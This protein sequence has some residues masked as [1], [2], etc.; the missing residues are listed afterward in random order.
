MKAPE[1]YIHIGTHKT[2]STAIRQALIQCREA[3][4]GQG[5]LYLPWDVRTFPR[6]SLSFMTMR[7][8]DQ[9]AVHHLR[10]M[11]RQARGDQRRGD[12]EG[13]RLL[14]SFEGFSGDPS[15]GYRNASV[16]AEHLRRATEGFK[17]HIIVYLR[18]QDEFIE[19]LYTQQIHEG[20]WCSFPDFV[21]RHD[22]SS[23][24]NWH[25]LLR[26]YSNCFGKDRMIVRRYHKQFF[27]CNESLL[28]DFFRILG[29]D[30][31]VLDL[32]PDFA[33]NRGYSR[34]ALEIAR[35]ANPHLTDAER[36][37][38]RQLLQ[39]TNAKQPFEAYAFWS[40]REREALASRYRESNA[41]VAQEYFGE[42]SG[43]LFPS[44]GSRHEEVKYAGLSL[45][46]VTLAFA[47]IIL[48]E[49]DRPVV[50]E[51]ASNNESVLLKALVRVEKRASALLKKGS[52][53]VSRLRSLI[54][55]S[56]PLEAGA[57]VRGALGSE[58]VCAMGSDHPMS[59]IPVRHLW[60]SR[61]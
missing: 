42:S 18:P 37:R 29:V 50:I 32:P 40:E 54:R 55:T 15:E 8:S 56:R 26:Q 57:I 41:K 33:P 59:A 31:S 61:P 36:S 16:I 24:F 7:M 22:D 1:L 48:A 19:S 5:V 27:P 12:P 6:E 46:A 45:E 38:L 4:R 53:L 9:N 49:R 44:S 47:K 3:L 43:M 11:L 52:S 23:S 25:W 2:G 60:R 58:R 21:N 17:T 30:S 39:R 35:I 51:T 34:D 20:K 13:P 28:Q 10:K 14:M